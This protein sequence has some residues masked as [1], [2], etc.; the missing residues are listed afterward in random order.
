M[1]ARMDVIYLSPSW[2]PEQVHFTR[3]LHAVGARAWGVG[4]GPPGAADPFLA[5]HLQVPAMGDEDDV[6]RRVLRW[7]DGRRPDRVETNWEPMVLAA[8]RLRESLDLPGL[9][10]RDALPFRDKVHMHE[11]VARAGL[12][13]A[14]TARV[15]SVAEALEGAEYV[16]YPCVFK[17]VAGAGGA[18]TFRA[19]DRDAL[20]RGL[21]AAGHVPE[22]SLEEWVEGQEFTYETICVDGQ[23][24]LESVCLYLPNV[25]DARRTEWIS[26]IIAS[27]RDL[28]D[29]WIAPGVEL[30]RAALNAMN[31]G[32]GYTHMEWFRNAAGEAVF[33]EIACRAP[34]A[35]MVDLLNYTL[36]A[37]T[38]VEWARAVCHGHVQPGLT[39][40][41]N[42]VM[43]FKRAQGQGRIQAIEGVDE[44]VAR[45]APWLACVDLLPVGAPRRDWTQTFLSDGHV[46]VRH[47]DWGTAMELGRQV[48]DGVR[49]IAG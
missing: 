3:G 5:G 24:V 38:Y 45:H 4:D 27:I 48:R 36:D 7:L 17:P 19:D 6:V 46:V 31:A 12:R 21:S 28:N 11:V 15:R 2:P 41:F 25:L 14:R 20:L 13:V 43:V 16:G 49:L 18:D 35:S 29:P 22:A 47:P 1:L 34:G 32:T 8:A 26:P 30:G 33:G 42:A 39:R 23:P 9:R 44:L 40:K 37:D 10:P